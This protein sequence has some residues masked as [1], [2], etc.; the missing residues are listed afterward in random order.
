MDLSDSCIHCDSLKEYAAGSS[1]FIS[2]N[3]IAEMPDGDLQIHLKIFD[4]HCPLGLLREL[5]KC[6]TEIVESETSLART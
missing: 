1:Y 3:K 6:R 4:S 2:L 5:L